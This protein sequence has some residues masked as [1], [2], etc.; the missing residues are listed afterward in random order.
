MRNLHDNS[1]KQNQGRGGRVENKRG[2]LS[3][4]A[5]IEAAEE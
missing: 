2:A 5:A 4:D 3:E 1:H